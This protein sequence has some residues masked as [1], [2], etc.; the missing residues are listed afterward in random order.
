VY[1]RALAQTVGTAVM[2]LA[3][4]DVLPYQFTGLAETVGRY[5]KEVAKLLKDTQDPIRERNRELDDGLFA[6]TTDPREPLVPPA[7]QELPP[8][9]NFAPLDNAVDLLTRAADRYEHAFG[10]AQANG[11]AA[12]GRP[13]ARAVNTA[14]IQSE[15]ALM[16]AAGLPRRPWYRHAVYAPGFYTGYGVKTLPGVREAIEQKNWQEAEQ[17]ILVV[18]KALQA[19]ADVVTRAADQLEKLTP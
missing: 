19:A 17:Q 14:L 5:A 18:G 7:R 15:R 16:S 9:L 3:D 4:A 1:G 12:L 13:E 8:F 6:A 10:R 11:G 2:R